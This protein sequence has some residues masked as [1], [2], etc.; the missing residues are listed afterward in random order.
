M[1]RVVRARQQA[2]GEQRQDTRLVAGGEVRRRAAVTLTAGGEQIKQSS[3]EVLL[4]ATVHNSGTWAMMI[5]D[6]KASLQSQLR[7][8]VN[9][10]IML[11]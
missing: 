11:I 4:G 2:E 5:G 9:A 7:S 10:L 8:R 3:S 1:T 6:G